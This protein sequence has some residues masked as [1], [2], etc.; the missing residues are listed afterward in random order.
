MRF[1]LDPR[2]PEGQQQIGEQL[3][4]GA[5]GPLYDAAT[6]AA[7]AAVR[8]RIEAAFETAERMHPLQGSVH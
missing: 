1:P 3:A 2:T 8:E 5:G 7:A 4:R 6:L